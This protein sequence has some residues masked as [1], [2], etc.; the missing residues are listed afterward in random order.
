M[1]DSNNAPTGDVCA[2]VQ[3][4]KKVKEAAK[5]AEQADQKYSQSVDACKLIQDKHYNEEMPRVLAVCSAVAI[6]SNHSHTIGSLADLLTALARN[7]KVL[8]RHASSV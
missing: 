4:N 8:K 5:K 7:W 6:R 3:L 1:G 2:F